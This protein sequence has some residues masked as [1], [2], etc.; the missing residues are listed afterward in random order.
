MTDTPLPNAARI[1]AHLTEIYPDKSER[2]AAFR[3]FVVDIC[4]RFIQLGLADHHFVERVCSQD[5]HRHWQALSE[6]L[7][8][9]EFLVAGIELH[10]SPTGPDLVFEHEGR[11]IWVEITCPTPNDVPAEWLNPQGIDFVVSMPHHAISGS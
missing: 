9:H 10:P 6:P 1:A 7:V 3:T 2:V 5:R 11:R 4:A 8:A